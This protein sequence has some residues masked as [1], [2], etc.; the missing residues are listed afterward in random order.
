MGAEFMTET[1]TAK[2]S[3][4][5]KAKHDELVERDQYDHGHAGY[6]GTFAE[7]PGVTISDYEAK[8]AEDAEQYID[9][10]AKKWENSIAVRI[11]GTD[12]WVIGGVF[13]S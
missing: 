4:E 9:D 2:T 5:V 3:K 6:S 10:N 1:I 8:D 11:K 12:E 7:S 13:S